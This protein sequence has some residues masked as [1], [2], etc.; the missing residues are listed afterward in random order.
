MSYQHIGQHGG[1][2][3]DLSFCT[4]PS[5][6]DEIAPLKAELER[7]G[8]AVEERIKVTRQ[9]DEVRRASASRELQALV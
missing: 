7:I 2:S 4:R 6:L 5:T 1:A 8:Y 9:M 3:P